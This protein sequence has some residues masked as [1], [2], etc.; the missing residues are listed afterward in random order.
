MRSVE[1]KDSFCWFS[2]LFLGRWRPRCRRRRRNSNAH[3]PRVKTECLT[4]FS[5]LF[6]ALPGVSWSFLRENSRCWRRK[7]DRRRQKPRRQLQILPRVTLFFRR[8][9]SIR[10]PPPERLP[11]S[12][13]S[14]PRPTGH[15]APFLPP[16]A[17]SLNTARKKNGRN[18]GIRARVSLV[19]V[20][21]S[22]QKRNRKG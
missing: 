18:R 15:A 13:D 12:P 2:G 10:A 6:F 7:P 11:R 8:L 5:P 20:G 17:V 22:S 21:S 16:D 14:L 19:V 1:K 3:R 4:P 9:P